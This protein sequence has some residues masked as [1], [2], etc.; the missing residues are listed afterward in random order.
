MAGDDHPRPT[1]SGAAACFN[2]V[3]G[4]AFVR[5][6]LHQRFDWLVIGASLVVDIDPV[7]TRYVLGDGGRDR[8]VLDP[9]GLRVG[10]T[11]TA[12]VTID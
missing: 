3:R 12:G 4:D 11:L 6:G 9:Y 1:C 8:I 10:T 2:H 5:A 7:D